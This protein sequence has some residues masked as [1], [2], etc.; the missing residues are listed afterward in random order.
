MNRRVPA[1]ACSYAFGLDIVYLH[2]D[3]NTQVLSVFPTP[4]SFLIDEQIHYTGLFFPWHRYY[5]QWFENMLVEKCGYK[6][7]TPYWDWTQGASTAFKPL[8]NYAEDR[9]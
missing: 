1:A 9:F 6:G 5:V 2:M 4:Q 8:W 3:L 7:T